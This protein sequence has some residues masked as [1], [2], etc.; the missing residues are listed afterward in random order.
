MIPTLRVRR[1]R[2]HPRQ[3]LIVSADIGEGHDLPARALAAQLRDESPGIEVATVDG[4]RAM[5][6]LLTLVVRDGSWLSFNWL[7]WLF[8]AQ[9]SLAVR[10]P[11]T[12]WLT[13]RLGCLL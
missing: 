1:C 10:F 9:Y 12:R 13:L 2:D 4:L 6:R 3:V 7:P 8:E 5:G 11:P